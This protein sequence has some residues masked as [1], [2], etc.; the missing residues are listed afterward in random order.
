MAIEGAMQ[1]KGGNWQ[2]FQ[3][4]LR[5]SEA[6]TLL[7]TTVTE[8]KKENR[9]Y[10]VE[11]SPAHDLTG[12]AAGIG[13]TFDTVVLAAPLQF[14]NIRLQKDLVRHVPDEIPYVKLHV[15]LFTSPLK[16]SGAYFNL[17]EGDEVPNTVLTTLSPGE[18]SSD[19]KN[20]VGK[21]GFFSISTLRSIIN[22]NTMGKE[23]VYKIFS[24]EKVTEEFLTNLFGIK[25][26]AYRTKFC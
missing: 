20:I 24:P 10:I 3:H 14:T 17:K 4:F 8:I 7:N 22:P 23:Y 12:E 18:D 2:I 1:V 11:T 26:K 9:K 6:N 21:A 19:R 13:M 15:T 5:A 25:C 16:F